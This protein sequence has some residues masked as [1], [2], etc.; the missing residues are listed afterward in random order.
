MKRVFVACLLVA[1]SSIAALAQTESRAD[2]LKAIETERAE[3]AKLETSFL[4]PTAEDRAAYSEFLSQPDTGMIRLLPREKFDSHVNPKSGVTV[5]GGGAY[6]SFVRLSHEYQE[7]V[8]IGLERGQLTTGF[9]GY[10]YGMLTQ[11]EGASLE[12]I[13]TELPGVMFL[14]N[15]KPVTRDTEARSEQRR[16]QLGTEV[17]GAAYK[18]RVKVEIGATYLLRHI[19]FETSDVLVALKV[20]RQDTDGSLIIAWKLLQKYSAPKLARSNQ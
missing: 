13:S 19:S 16:F 15:Y 3:L 20:V 8:D 1:V 4:S 10:D 7:G 6:Y 2:L 9:G 5:N 11:P 17:A 18:E 14:A 12:D